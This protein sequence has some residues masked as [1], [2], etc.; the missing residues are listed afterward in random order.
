MSTKSVWL[1][2]I[3]IALVI[4]FLGEEFGLIIGHDL[5]KIILLGH[6]GIGAI[7][8]TILMIHEERKIVRNEPSATNLDEWGTILVMYLALA[9]LG[10]AANHYIW[11]YILD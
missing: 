9:G 8:L 1:I 11:A 10:I 4:G 7:P 5:G 3:F 2:Y 6:M